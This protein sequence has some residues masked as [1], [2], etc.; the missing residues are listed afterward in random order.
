[1]RKRTLLAATL[2]AAALLHTPDHAGAQPTFPTKPVAMVVPFAAGGPTDVLARALTEPL[3]RELGQAVVVENVTGAGGTIGAG[4]V[5]GARPDGHTLLL[6]NIGLATSG[7]L[8]RRL[9]YD[10][11]RSFE[12]IGLVSPVPMALV[13]RPDLPVHDLPGL[14]A[15]AREKGADVN[16]AHAGVG[17]ASHLC[18]TL[19]RSITRIPMTAVA[20]RGTAPVMTEMLAGRIDLTCDQTTNAMP[21]IQE[22][23]VRALA[24]TTSE[25]LPVLPEVPTTAEGGLPA[26]QVTIWHGLYAPKGTPRP[27]VER[28]SQA[29]RAALRDERVVQ[30]L[31]ELG[32]AP[33]PQER[34]TPEAHRAM[35]D[36][37]VA[38]WR[39]ILQAAGEFA[40]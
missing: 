31:A 22:G 19:L 32:S 10:P 1:M 12:T 37:E 28:L 13:A 2:G 8:Y 21:Y 11:A 17:S 35:L 40:D 33:E 20:F 15:W 16:L 7:T 39:P 24:V 23:R 26:L 25:R 27:A 5:A 34:A 3:A 14:L 9:P 36:A 29:L 4:R 30:R 18:A 6:G 38:R